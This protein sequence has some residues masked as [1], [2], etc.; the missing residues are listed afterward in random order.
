ML[1][2][3]TWGFDFSR[4]MLLILPLLLFSTI[5][6]SQNKAQIRS[7]DSAAYIKIQDSLKNK[8]QQYDLN[9]EYELAAL[10][11]MTYYP[12]LDVNNIKFEDANTTTTANARPRVFSCIFRKKGNRRYLIRINNSNKDSVLRVNLLS[13]NAKTG[14][15]GH[16]LAH[17]K[18]YSEL[19]FFGLLGRLFSY[20]NKKK[21][22]AYEKATDTEAINRGLGWQVY[23]FCYFVH[24]HSC[25][26]K[27]YKDY[28][29]EI[30]YLP[31]ELKNII[32]SQ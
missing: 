30:Y 20:L 27:K 11:A 9:P 10:I 15:I 13:L 6:F 2:N 17:I 26:T 3:L 14:L 7:I 18:D 5:V 23:D 28:K 22:S 25:A 31:E 12:D 29:K 19:N 32:D 16:E 21:R 1:K 8:F 4:R 24:H